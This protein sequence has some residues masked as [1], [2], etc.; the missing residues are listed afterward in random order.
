MTLPEAI[1]P[2]QR[3]DRTQQPCNSLTVRLCCGRPLAH[4]RLHA[5]ASTQEETMKL[6]TNH[7]LQKLTER[8]LSALFST[9][10][11]GLVRTRRESPERTNVLASLE[12]ISLARAVLMSGSQP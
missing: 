1:R 3:T 4:E 9:V 10:S 11:K 12:N 7:E 8:E 2:V 5:G 6:I